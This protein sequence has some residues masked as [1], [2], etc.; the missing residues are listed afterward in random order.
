MLD[1][2]LDMLTINSLVLISCGGEIITPGKYLQTLKHVEPITIE[3]I[4]CNMLLAHHFKSLIQEIINA[5][6]V[7]TE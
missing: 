4:F 3:S 7:V 6:E 5:P 2:G 1:I